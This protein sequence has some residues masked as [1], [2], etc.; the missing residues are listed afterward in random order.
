MVA[1]MPGI[2][3]SRCAAAVNGAVISSILVPGAA[4]PASNAP[5]R[6]SIR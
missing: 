1:L 5:A 6:A 2:S 3:S 4:I